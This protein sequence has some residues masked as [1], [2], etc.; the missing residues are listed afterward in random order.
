MRR[1]PDGPQVNKVGI[2]LPRFLLE[3]DAW[4]SIVFGAPVGISD[5]PDLPTISAEEEKLC[6]YQ[7]NWPNPIL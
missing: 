4:P 5:L 3:K 2:G 6:P 1:N 7:D